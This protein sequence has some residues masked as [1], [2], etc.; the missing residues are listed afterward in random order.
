ML[1]EAIDNILGTSAAYTERQF[2]QSVASCTVPRQ[3]F[4]DAARAMKKSYAFLAAEWATDETLFGGGF[5]VYACYRWGSEYLIVRTEVPVDD[6]TF[7]SLTKKYLPAYRF[8]RQIHSLMGLV[9]VGHPDLRPWIK[10]EDWPQDAYPLRKTFDAL[11]PMPRVEGQYKWTRASGEGVYEIPVGPVHAGIIEPGHFRFQA[12]GEMILNLEERLGY[13]HKGIEKRFESLSWQDGVKLAARVSGDTTVAHSIA[14]SMAVEAMTQSNIPERAHYLRALFLERE[15]IANHIGDIGAICNDAAF[16]FML[17][18]LMRLKEILLRTNH[19]LF[20]HRFIMDKVIPGGVNIDIDENGKKEIISEL[21]I[22]SR[23]FEKLI[24]IYDKNSSLEDRVRDTGILPPEKARELCAVG[25]V[26]RASGLNVDCRVQN[27]FPPYDRFEVNVPVLISGDVHARVW[28]RVEEI[29]ESIRIIK[30]IL[31]NIPDGKLSTDITKPLP[32]TAGF[33]SVEGWRGE[34]IYWV[35]SGP[36]GGINRCMVRDPS[37]VN[38]LGLEQAIHGN[39]VP[40]FP[41]CNKSFNQSYSGHD[42]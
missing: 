12:V 31:E 34:I 1:K 24:N 36:D 21:D 2:P 16:A 8:E 17:Y 6:P 38:W 13:V 9:P 35:Q 37:S 33:S 32:D 14:Y 26:A 42:L 28:V 10:F 39:I 4:V 5:A 30:Y 7:P 15:R 20:G 23:D 25:I 29:R 27:P 22:V 11:K 18:Q 40:D 19:R 41:L 3:R